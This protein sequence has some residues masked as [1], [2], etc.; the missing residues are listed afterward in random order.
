MFQIYALFV[1]DDEA[2]DALGWSSIYSNAIVS[3]SGKTMKP[4]FFEVFPFLKISTLFSVREKG[5]PLNFSRFFTPLPLG[6]WRNM[7]KTP[8]LKALGWI[9]EIWLSVKLAKT[10]YLRFSKTPTSNLERPDLHMCKYVNDGKSLNDLDGIS[11]ILDPSILN[12]FSFCSPVTLG[13]VIICEFSMLNT[14]NSYKKSTASFGRLFKLDSLM[15]NSV[16]KSSTP[17][18]AFLSMRGKAKY[19]IRVLIH[20]ILF[21][22]LL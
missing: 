13:I 10:R 15:Y 16:R 11:L 1:D 4:F 20:M 9:D 14:L 3:D 7:W 12:N 18:K 21:I 5:L 8:Y 2:K 22:F 19:S 6:R 17:A